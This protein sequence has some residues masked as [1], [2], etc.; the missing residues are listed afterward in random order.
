[1]EVDPSPTGFMGQDTTMMEPD[2]M[3]PKALQDRRG[4][5]GT[6]QTPSSQL[7]VLAM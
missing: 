6:P 7:A 2:P 3:E 4:L 5:L 1:M